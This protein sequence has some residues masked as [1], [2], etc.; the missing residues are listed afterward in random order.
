MNTTTKKPR[1][2]RANIKAIN[3]ST[4]PITNQYEVMLRD[5]LKELGMSPSLV[6]YEYLVE[7]VLLCMDH[8]DYALRCHL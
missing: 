6:G 7:C 1:V 2:R 3:L 5:K 4:A 8:P